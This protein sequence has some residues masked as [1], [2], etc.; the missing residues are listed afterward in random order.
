MNDFKI[1]GLADP[2]AAQQAATK[3]YV[4]DKMGAFSI[5]EKAIPETTACSYG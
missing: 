3:K 2:T 5:L 1:T 4:D